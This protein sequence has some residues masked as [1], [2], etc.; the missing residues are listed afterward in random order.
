MIGMRDEVNWAA[1]AERLVFID[2]SRSR[3]W[4]IQG[5]GS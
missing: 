5:G 1:Q 3:P 4:A 2:G